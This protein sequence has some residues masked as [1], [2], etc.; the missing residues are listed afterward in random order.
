M[1]RHYRRLNFVGR[2]F[3]NEL[4]EQENRA[5]NYSIL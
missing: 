3:V 1:Q 4:V 5:E 2:R